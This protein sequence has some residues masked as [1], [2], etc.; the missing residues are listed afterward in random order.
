MAPSL[1]AS[2]LTGGRNMDGTFFMFLV[3]QLYQLRAGQCVTFAEQ[4]NRFFSKRDVKRRHQRRRS[5]GVF[6]ISE[7]WLSSVVEYLC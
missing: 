5:I 3:P 4:L 1:T 7:S 6:D 2:F